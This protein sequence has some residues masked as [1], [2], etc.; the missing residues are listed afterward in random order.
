[1]PNALASA[2]PL[3]PIV[4]TLDAVRARQGAAR[5]QGVAPGLLVADRDGF[6]PAGQFVDG[7]ALPRLINAAVWRWS[8]PRHVAAALAWKQYTYWLLLPAVLGYARAR[9]VPRLSAPNVLV[10]P[11]WDAALV[12]IGLAAPHAT[13]LPGDHL[14][15]TP[16]VSVAPDEQALLGALRA[17]V[18]DEHLTPMLDRLHEL[19][20]LGRHNLLGSVASAIGYALVRARDELPGDVIADARAVL[21]ALGV[22]DLVQLS[23][24]GRVR[25]RTCC[26]AFALPEPKICDGC[27]ISSP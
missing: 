19:A 11:R 26:L 7:T 3:A 27:C 13:V 8:A 22:D 21:A 10:Q 4:G 1:V 25:R 2:D 12:R 6:I 15:G 18:L 16:G 23:P 9:R 20:H 5:V 14:A 24:D 17:E